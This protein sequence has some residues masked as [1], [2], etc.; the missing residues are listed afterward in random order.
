[1]IKSSCGFQSLKSSIFNPAFSTDLKTFLFFSKPV[2]LHRVGG[3]FVLHFVLGI[4]SLCT[5]FLEYFEISRCGDS[6]R[7]LFSSSRYPSSSPRHVTA[8]PGAS[9]RTCP[10]WAL[11]TSSHSKSWGA[12]RPTQPDPA[13]QGG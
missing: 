8:A 11:P 6:S 12:E 1:M 9:L 7:F 2:L 13:A 4:R 5:F 3:C 10:T